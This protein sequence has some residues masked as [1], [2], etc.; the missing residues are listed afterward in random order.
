[1]KILYFVKESWERE[2]ITKG[3][4]GH[5]VV[6]VD[7]MLGEWLASHTKEEMVTVEALSVFVTSPVGASELAQ[8]PNLKLITTRSTGFDHID[9]T[10]ARARG[11][12]VATVPA[13][14][15]NTV[16]EFAFALILALSRRTG[17]ARARTARDHSLSQEGLRGFDLAGKTLG[18]VGCGHI[19]QHAARM[20]T[21]FGMTVL[22]YDEHQDAT[23]ASSLGFHYVTL[24]ELLAAS[25]II[26]L[27]TPHTPQ[28]HH[29]INKE[30]LA[31][32]KKGAYLINTA[33]GAL[34]D[35]A[36][37][38][39]AIRSGQLAGAG[40]DVLENEQELT[41]DE[42]FLAEHPRVIVTPHVAF[43]TDEAVVRI[44][45]TTIEN[46]TAFAAGMPQ[47]LAS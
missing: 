31:Q 47:N 9:S 10:A 43:N 20:G 16:A 24:P 17:E 7:D 5:E 37:L 21:G 23:L 12:L 28:T 6:C 4:P 22:V 1:M 32:C 39:E 45:D 36:A 19:G 35:T 33:R 41:P 26:T 15:A 8:F 38:V 11:V 3:L 27:H 2:Y 29:L 14:G 42:I 25:D 46:I 30:T 40:L 44:V 13:Y 34:V 18:V